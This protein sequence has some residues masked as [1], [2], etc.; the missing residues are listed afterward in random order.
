MAVILFVPIP[1]GT[2][3][4]GGTREWTALTYKLV[5]WN[6]IG[7][8]GA[9]RK[10]RIYF[11]ADRF[12][13]ID[14]LWA[15]ECVNAEH[16]FVATVIEIN[17]DAVIVEP[18]QSATELNSSGEISFSAKDMDIGAEMGDIVRVTYVGNVM[19]SY[20]AMVN[21]VNWELVKDLRNIEYIGD[22]ID[23]Q[24]AERIDGQQGESLSVDAV[25]TE[26]YADCFFAR[27][28][29][30]SPFLY[31]FN[32]SLED[33]WCIGDQVLVAYASGYLKKDA[34]RE[35][36]QIRIEAETIAVEQSTFELQEGVAYKPIIYLYPECETEVSV[37]LDLDG[38]LSCTYPSY[39]DGW[40]VTAAPDGTLTDA[41][42]QIYNYLYW[43][44][45]ISADWDM[46][47][48]FC[49]KG[50]DTAAF[51]EA[52]LKQ[53]GLTRREANEFIVF[54]L[55]FMQNNE[56]NVICFQASAYTE[57]ARLDISPQPDTLCRVFMT[58]MA[59][60]KYVELEPQALSA[61]ERRGFTVVEWGGAVIG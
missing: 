12:K 54:W 45:E 3:D 14:E 16:S 18:I 24:T 23:E 34:Y 10:A 38:E 6:R 56:Y 40:T 1:R 9:Y 21:A 15:E 61:P 17:G 4:D 7:N 57:A 58:Y 2:L 8:N 5:D 47:R 50:E 51:L 31:K 53:L 13:S 44:G 19:E 52:A 30:M 29:I 28:V 49:V 27:P 60:D 39:E 22:W 55:P 48:G 26:I 37:K 33:E 43:E 11:G 36:G 46:S 25:I 20:P 41:N 59:S 35:N 42:G 32:Y